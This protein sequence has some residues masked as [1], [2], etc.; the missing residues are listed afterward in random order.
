MVIAVMGPGW[1]TFAL[2]LATLVCV[3]IAKQSRSHMDATSLPSLT[4]RLM[5]RYSL[6]SYRE[7]E[8]QSYLAGRILAVC[9]GFATIG[10]FVAWIFS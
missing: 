2:L 6:E 4:K 5:P 9:L 3:F 10:S 7:G 8:R 1:R